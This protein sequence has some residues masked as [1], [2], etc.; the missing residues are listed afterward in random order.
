[1]PFDT[2][3]LLFDSNP[4]RA[5]QIGFD[6]SRAPLGANTQLPTYYRSAPQV[7]PIVLEGQPFAFWLTVF[8]ATDNSQSTAL[9]QLYGCALDLGAPATCLG[10]ALIATT[11]LAGSG[12]AQQ[13]VAAAAFPGEAA[14]AVAH[15]DGAG[16]SW[17]R[18]ADLSC[19]R[20]GTL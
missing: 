10:T 17:L 12:I 6:L 16:Q 14:F 5:T 3:L 4:V 2:G 19:A 18:V 20:F 11:G 7:A 9:H 1:M 8:P 15:T 13:P